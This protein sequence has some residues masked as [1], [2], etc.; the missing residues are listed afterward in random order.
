[1]GTDNGELHDCDLAPASSHKQVIGKY[2]AG[3]TREHGQAHVQCHKVFGNTKK[4]LEIRVDVVLDK[5]GFNRALQTA[6]NLNNKH[7]EGNNYPLAV[8]KHCAY[9]FKNPGFFYGLVLSCR[10]NVF[11]RIVA[12][13]CPCEAAKKS[14][15]A[16]HGK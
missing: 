13:A 4:A 16:N 3:D 15:D 8:A 14:Q 10:A 11:F 6:A 2:H 5:V 1:N 12:L 9:V 7:G